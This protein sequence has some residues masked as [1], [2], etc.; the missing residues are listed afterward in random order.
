MHI[1]RLRTV[2]LVVIL[3]VAVVTLLAG[4]HSAIAAAA[5]AEGVAR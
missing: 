1:V 2:L 4:V 3:V 5:H